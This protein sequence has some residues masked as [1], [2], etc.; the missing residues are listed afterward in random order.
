[1]LSSEVDRNA[2]FW[3]LPL[4]NVIL[5]IRLLLKFCQIG[6]MNTTM[7]LSTS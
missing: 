7:C 4:L 6:R 5:Y 2:E 3:G 1:M